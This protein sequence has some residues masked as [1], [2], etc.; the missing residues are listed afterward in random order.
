MSN[1]IW[2]S[3]EF[4]RLNNLDKEDRVEIKS[5]SQTKSYAKR[6]KNNVG[7]KKKDFFIKINALLDFGRNKK[8]KNN[9][10]IW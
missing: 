3:T 1:N 8:I 9:E 5:E 7:L 2:K 6:K 10:Y 4:S